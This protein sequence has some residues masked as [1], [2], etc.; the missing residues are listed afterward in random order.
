M[1]ALMIAVR[2]S[3]LPGVTVCLCCIGLAACSAEQECQDDTDIQIEQPSSQTGQLGAL[4]PGDKD[5]DRLRVLGYLD[6]SEEPPQ[7]PGEGTVLWEQEKAQPG[8]TLIVY[9]GACACDLIKLDGTVVQSW[10]DRECHRWEQA[11]L[12]SDGDLLVVGTDQPVSKQ[13]EGRFLLRLRWDGSVRWRR[14]LS[15]HHDIEETPDGLWLSLMMQPRR[16]DE[17]DPDID[18][19]DD[20]LTLLDQDGRVV[21][22][23]SLYDILNS[24]K[25]RFPIQM[26]GHSEKDGDTWIDLFH[27]NAAEWMR[28]EQLFDRHPLYGPDNIL[29]TSRHQDAVMVIN[30]RTRQLVWYWG[31]GE[32]SGPH[33]ATVLPEG[34]LLIFDNGLTRRWSRVI[35][36]DP[37][38]GTIVR[39]YTTPKKTDFFSRVMGSC[40]KLANGNVLIGNS[41]AGQGLELTLEGKPAWVFLGTRKT[42]NGFREKI[43]RIRRMAD[44]NVAAILAHVGFH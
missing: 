29:I 11:H 41:A 25:L 38:S 21:E 3:L 27:C 39:K 43:P 30:W 24:S 23:L 13:M 35:E 12:L 33:S 14:R 22:T 37:L 7:I 42:K 17:I 40:Q 6:L 2:V 4:N 44:A 9:A 26:A 32:L 34:N 10:Q 36:V 15:V 16:V 1:T 20:I 8:Y 19:W 18:I 31:P 5:L 28:Y